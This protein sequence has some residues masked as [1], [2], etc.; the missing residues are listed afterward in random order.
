MLVNLRDLKTN[1]F[2]DLIVDPI[3]P[4]A[5]A[6]LTDS[7]REDGFWGGVVARHN[8]DGEIEIAAG[9]HRVKAAIAAGI[10]S[11]D[12]FIGDID[13]AGMIRIYA[14][15]NA[16]QRGNGSTAVAGT[17]ASAIRFLAKE[18]FL[19][20]GKFSSSRARARSDQDL[21]APSILAF[22][23]GIPG[24]NEGTVKAQLANLK[25]SGDYA[26]II[27]EVQSEV[28]AEIAAEQ[29][30]IKKATEAEAKARQEAEA[31]AAREAE[32]ARKAA[33][34]AK[35][36]ADAARAAKASADKRAAEARSKAAEAERL[37]AERRAAESAKRAAEQAR[38]SAERQEALTKEAEKFD[39]MRSKAQAAADKA[40]ER[41]ITFDFEGVARHFKN[42]HQV[43]VFREMV[44]S[45]GIRSHLPVENQ[46]KVAAQLIKLA[47]DRGI[48]EI[49]GAF[50]RAELMTQIFG[51]YQARDSAKRDQAKADLERMDREQKMLLAQREFS[52]HV[53]GLAAAANDISDISRKW[54]KNEPMQVSGEFSSALEKLK[55]AVT[56]LVQRGLA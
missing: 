50:I 26:R 56:L 36:A 5:V 34:H 37:A 6:V 23:D 1:P 11:A 19:T 4:E 24:V 32:N 20:A 21:G 22:L 2:R 3:D 42:E 25:A 15:E 41:E 28:D 16:S 40:A 14:R 10:K 47:K 27:G 35:A 8:D 51:V 53:R 29:E 54:P 30:R 13:D 43:R 38:A 39:A 49:S 52:R 18:Q 33:E 12:L 44:T 48:E 45:E 31:R 7:I 9:H 46:A 55:A 17:V